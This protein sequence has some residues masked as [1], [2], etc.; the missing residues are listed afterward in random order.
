[1]KDKVIAVRRELL[2]AFYDKY[3][4]SPTAQIGWDRDE[5]D[6]D[7]AIRTREAQWL[8]EHGLIAATF[9]AA[10]DF[11][12][13]LTV[14]G[15]DFVDAGGFD[16]SDTSN[17]SSPRSTGILPMKKPRVFIGSSVE[18]LRIAKYIQLELEHQAEC[19]LWSQ[20]VFGLSGGTL[21]SLLQAVKEFEFAVLVLTPDDLV[22]K[23]DATKNSPRDNV[24]FEL[25]LFMGALGREK[26]YIVHCRD[27]KIDLPTDL[28]GITAAT[29]A[30]RDDG[31][32][33]A[34][35]GPVCTRIEAAIT[36]TK[37]TKANP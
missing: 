9:G 18:G 17:E 3:M 12:A 1:M 5:T 6:P 28:A 23:R 15:R 33:H 21:E 16:R 7:S 29:Y 24:L 32:L 11:M 8:Q 30:K 14:K 22:H 10:G 34:A 31:N 36:A 27:E 25:G 19:T 35:I 37:A 13:K 26:T 4:E 20:G 2:R